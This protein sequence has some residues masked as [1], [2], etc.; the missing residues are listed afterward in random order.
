MKDIFLNV[1]LPNIP[2]SRYVLSI[3]MHIEI[4]EATNNIVIFL[5]QFNE[6]YFIFIRRS[7]D[8]F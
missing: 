3:L 5:K 7:N 1:D 6:D 2:K 8:K 4:I